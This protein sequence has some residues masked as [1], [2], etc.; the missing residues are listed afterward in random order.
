[1]ISMSSLNQ[2]KHLTN[3]C[4]IHSCL[5]FLYKVLKTKINNELLSTYLTFKDMLFSP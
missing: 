3:F 2:Q 5:K 4:L 1:M